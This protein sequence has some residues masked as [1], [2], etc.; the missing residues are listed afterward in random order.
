M[1]A[2]QNERIARIETRLGFTKDGERNGNGLLTEIENMKEDFDDMQKKLD[3]VI[4]SQKE[5]MIMLS[6]LENDFKIMSSSINKI[7]DEMKDNINFRTIAKWKNVIMGIAA[8]I[9]ALGTIG[10]FLYK[11]FGGK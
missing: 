8:L 11:I 7:N 2:K 6:S 10:G 1:T 9:V 3:E 4:L 5:L